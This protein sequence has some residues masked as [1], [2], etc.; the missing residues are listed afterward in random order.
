MSTT[1]AGVVGRIWSTLYPAKHLDRLWQF[2]ER[3]FAWL[4]FRGF[5][6]KTFVLIEHLV[7]GF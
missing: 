4:L 2:E 6:P 7:R 3:K 1:K 5:E